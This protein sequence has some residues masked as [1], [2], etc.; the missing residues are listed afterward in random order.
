MAHI[1]FIP[2]CNDI[3]TVFDTDEELSSPSSIPESIT[4]VQSVRAASDYS[5]K[6]SVQQ[7]SVQQDSVQQGSEKL[8]AS[9]S[10]VTQEHTKSDKS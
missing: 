3:Y 7:D 5:T 10:G 4:S 9:A 8:E 6:D 1:Y 2:A